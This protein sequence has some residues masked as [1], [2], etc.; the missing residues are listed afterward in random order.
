LGKSSLAS[1]ACL[2]QIGAFFV[3]LKILV[4]FLS[5]VSVVLDNLVQKIR[6]QV[7]ERYAQSNQSGAWQEL[8]K[9]F[10]AVLQEVFAKMEL[11]TREEFDRQTQRLGEARLKLQALEK[12]VKLLE[13]QIV[14]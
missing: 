12:Q 1:P 2:N 3:V 9:N 11:V 7:Q 13:E 8:D 10:H 4:R 6:E 14:K 5:E